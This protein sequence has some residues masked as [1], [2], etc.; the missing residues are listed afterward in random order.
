MARDPIRAVCQHESAHAICALE[1]GAGVDR[2]V[3]RSD[4]TG[5]ILT[6]YGL[7]DAQAAIYSAAGDLW[8]REFSEYDYVDGACF[9][10]QYQL[11]RVGTHGIWAARR[12]ARQIL[13][14]RRRDVLDLA[15]QL[16]QHRELTF[17]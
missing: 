13:A 4:G 14:A 8:D 5:G 1:L 3:V 2:I 16:R 11:G 12:G 7:P 6:R 15:G 17:R 10:L 9:D